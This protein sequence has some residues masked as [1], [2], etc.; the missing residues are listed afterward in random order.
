ML[1]ILLCSLAFALDGRSSIY[2]PSAESLLGKYGRTELSIALESNAPPTIGVQ[3][4]LAL[5]R[6]ILDVAYHHPASGMIGYRYPLQMKTLWSIAPFVSTQIDKDFSAT[7]G[8]SNLFHISTYKVDIST[9][10]I[11]YSEV[12]D[13]PPS[14]LRQLEAGFAFVPVPRQEIRIGY[15][16]RTNHEVNVRHQRAGDWMSTDIVLA[17]GLDFW[18]MQA[19]V[20]FRR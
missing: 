6:G 7:V 10:L 2:F 4:S 13:L 3:G 11:H 14:A 12:I 18:R 1:V 17:G 5:P 19:A 15:A 8:V 16:H 20:G 9:A